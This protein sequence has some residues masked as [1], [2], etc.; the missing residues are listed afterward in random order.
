MG[1]ERLPVVSWWLV[2][3]V[4]ATCSLL[5]Y[6]LGRYEGERVE[7]RRVADEK[8]RSERIAADYVRAQHEPARHAREN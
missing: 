7:Q 4:A 5:A 2:V 3:W 8:R 1:G 6:W